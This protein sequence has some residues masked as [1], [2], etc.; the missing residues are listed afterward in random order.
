MQV[1]IIYPGVL[2]G[3][4]FSPV[5][6]I[7]GLCCTFVLHDIPNSGVRVGNP[8]YQIDVSGLEYADD[9]GLLDENADESSE[10]ISAISVGSKRDASMV[11]SVAKTKAMH[12]HKKVRVSATTESEI[13]ALHLKHKCADCGRE[14]PTAKGLAIHRTRW[15][16]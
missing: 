2:Q 14:F 11:I 3:D 1:P 15:W 8:P 12:I 10:R 16:D 7:L 13:A 5:T 6:F 4:I 9:A